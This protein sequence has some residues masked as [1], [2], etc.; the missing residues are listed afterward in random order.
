MHEACHFTL[1]LPR[2]FA[3]I[4]ITNGGEAENSV[5]DANVSLR[6]G[7]KW[8]SGKLH[9]IYDLTGSPLTL[10]QVMWASPLPTGPT[11]TPFPVRG[12]ESRRLL[13]TFVLQFTLDQSREWTRV[14]SYVPPKRAHCVV[15]LAC[16]GRTIWVQHGS[17]WYQTH[18]GSVGLL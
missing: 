11:F 9:R 16:L 2:V 18:S 15:K 3:V 1:T 6:V 4:N 7:Q 5:Q 8:W 14:T 17:V 13:M 12:R 10:K